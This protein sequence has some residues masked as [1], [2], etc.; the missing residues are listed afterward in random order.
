[1]QTKKA[2]TD[3]PS[4]CKVPASMNRARMFFEIGGACAI[5]SSSVYLQIAAK[6]KGLSADRAA[7][8]ADEDLQLEEIGVLKNCSKLFPC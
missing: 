8:L 6:A 5:A 4:I 3:Q 1:M 2:P 7:T